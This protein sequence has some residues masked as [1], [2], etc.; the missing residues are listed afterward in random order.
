M[1]M[2]TSSDPVTCIE[3]SFFLNADPLGVFKTKRFYVWWCLPPEA[4]ASH[5]GDNHP[6]KTC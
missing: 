4:Y 2:T 1:G 6:R 3:A 5:L